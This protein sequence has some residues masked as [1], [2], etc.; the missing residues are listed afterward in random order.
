MRQAL[1]RHLIALMDKISYWLL[2]GSEPN[3]LDCDRPTRSDAIFK[4]IIANTFLNL[5]EDQW[6][7][8]M[9]RGGQA[10]NC[11]L[12]PIPVRRIIEVWR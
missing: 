12:H 11:Q 2:R 1:T 5:L 4:Y 6:D 7:T 3:F 10:A 8:A 9:Q